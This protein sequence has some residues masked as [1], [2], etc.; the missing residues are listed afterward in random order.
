MLPL[1]LLLLVTLAALAPRLAH[2]HGY[3]TAELRAAHMGGPPADRRFHNH[4]SAP[5]RKKHDLP[6]DFLW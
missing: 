3:R 1:K 5:F 4:V 2:T 6:K